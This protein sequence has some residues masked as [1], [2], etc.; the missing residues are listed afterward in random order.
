[1]AA[2]SA[3]RNDYWSRYLADTNPCY[4]PLLIESSNRETRRNR[5]PIQ[6]A[7]ENINGRVVEF[8]LKNELSVDT[9]FKAAWALAL[10]SYTGSGNLSF[11]SVMSTDNLDTATI[12]NLV[13]EENDSIL[14]L[15]QSI[16]ADAA[17]SLP[18]QILDMA[19]IVPFTGVDGRIPCN[20]TL[21]L[22]TTT[23]GK[24]NYLDH[25]ENVIDDNTDVCCLSHVSRALVYR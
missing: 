11:G 22:N 25:L 2:T 1:M 3:A 6:F 17:R 13:V 24:R 9:I 23:A 14:D 7:D 20:S 19:D 21:H 18:Y 12:C 16:A 15:A 8:C 5:L 10:K 4:F